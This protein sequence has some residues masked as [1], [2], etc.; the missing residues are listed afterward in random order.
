ML[1]RLTLKQAQKLIAD[2]LDNEDNDTENVKF[3]DSSD[4]S[5]QDHLELNRDANIDVCKELPSSV[6]DSDDDSADHTDAL[7]TD[8][9]EQDIDFI[10]LKD[11]NIRWH[12]AEPHSKKKRSGA[13]IVRKSSGRV[14]GVEPSEATDSFQLFFD[15]TILE[16]ILKATEKEANSVCL[17]KS[18]EHI[19]FTLPELKAFIGFMIIVGV[20]KGQNELINQL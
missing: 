20:T 7:S 1:K 3:D 17:K 2:W 15:D 8:A 9:Y 11:G 6:V 13:D 10:L 19:P 18:V 16:A 14:S 12:T 5:E 4:K